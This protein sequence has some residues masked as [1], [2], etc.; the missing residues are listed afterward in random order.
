MGLS[1]PD[2]FYKNSVKVL[3]GTEGVKNDLSIMLQC[4]KGEQLGDP[5]FGVNLHKSKFSVNPLLAKELAVDGI[6]EAQKF[7]G[8]IL[9][10]RDGVKV[11]KSGTA[12]IDI[13][14][15][16]VFSEAVNDKQLVVIEGVDL[17]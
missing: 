5:D 8:N 12:K 14:I 10:F 13:E 3:E 2:M 16:A 15:E 7:I 6:I 4:E 17:T 1:F 9:F 11:K